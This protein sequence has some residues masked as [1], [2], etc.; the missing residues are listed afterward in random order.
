MSLWRHIAVDPSYFGFWT[1]LALLLLGLPAALHL[2]EQRRQTREM[3]A[4]TVELRAIRR[5]V[6]RER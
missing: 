2:R 3:Q 1:L 5:A 4:Q 6:E